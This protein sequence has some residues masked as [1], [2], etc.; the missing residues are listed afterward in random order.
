MGKKMVG[1]KTNDFLENAWLL[2]FRACGG[3]FMLTHGIPKLQQ[4][5]AGGQIAFPDPFKIGALW[6][7]ALAVF[8]E[9]LCAVLVV[10]GIATRLAVIPLIVTMSVAAFYIHAHDKFASKEMALLYLLIYMTILVYGS[11]NF[12][13]GRIIRGN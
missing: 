6:S 12:A 13:L 7:L 10:L 11:G 2:A 5:F 1:S 9:V 8:A 3:G 4:L